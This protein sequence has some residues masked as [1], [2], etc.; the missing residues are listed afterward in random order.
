MAVCS[1]RRSPWRIFRIG[2]FD[3][4]GRDDLFWRNADGT[5]AVWYFAGGNLISASQ[6]FVG[7]PLSEWRLDATGDF[8]GDGRDD[9][10]WF[11]RNDGS[12]VRWLMRG[13]TTT[14]TFQFGIGVGLGW[15]VVQ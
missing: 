8:D 9:L 7:A 3:G 15:Q 1:R 2:D 6:F 12:T 14:P 11:N 13:R 4:D 10:M 5:N